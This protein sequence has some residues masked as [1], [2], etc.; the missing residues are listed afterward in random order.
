MNEP[1]KWLKELSKN[2]FPL[3]DHT[4]LFD[5]EPEEAMDRIKNRLDLI[6]FEKVAFLEK[7]RRNYKTLAKGNCFSILDAKLPIEDLLKQCID[8]ILS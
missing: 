8:I 6:P 4:F 2:R 5:I 3:P 7:V 1:I